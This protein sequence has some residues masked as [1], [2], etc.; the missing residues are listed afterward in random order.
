MSKF[1]LSIA[2]VFS[3]FTFTIA[4]TPVSN[5]PLSKQATFVESYSPSEVTIKAVGFG[6]KDRDALID[7]QKSAV[8]FVLYLGTD[9]L[10]RDEAAKNKFDAIAE[11]FFA[12]QKIFT[13]ISWQADKVIS[14]VKTRL[15]NKKKG[16]KIKKMVRVNKKLLYDELSNKGIISNVNDLAAAI[17]LPTI[18]VIPE[19]KRGQSPLTVFE[20][21]KFATTAA[22]TIESYL[23]AKKYDVIVPRAAEQINE[24]TLLQSQIKDVNDDMGYQLAL[25]LGS[26]IYI[27]FAG[28][29][30]GN[31]AS[32]SVKAY[33]TTT[34]RLLGTETGYSKDR[35]GASQQALVEEAIH[36]AI[37]NVLSRITTYWK[38]DIKKG[39]QYKLIFKISATLTPDDMEELQDEISDLIDDEFDLSKENILSGK[40]MDYT[41]WAKKEQFNKASKIYR[42]FRDT[43]SSKL[44]LKKISINKKLIIID[45]QNIQ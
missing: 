27:V 4:R 45:I 31:K 37:E 44:K 15:P 6:R 38:D 39:L 17:G 10:L 23:T 5:I 26:D 7:L 32:V 8:Y 24:Q 14:T 29:I 34:G 33:E 40:T 41:I 1:L 28:E 36:D 43:F 2:V 35:P 18:M 20:K 12:S 16:L 42:F 11:E 22:A 21:N 19:V 13:F 30:A 9:P 25:A 3:L